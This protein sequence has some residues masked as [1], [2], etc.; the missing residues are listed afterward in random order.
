[1]DQRQTYTVLLFPVLLLLFLS[2]PW[3]RFIPSP[4]LRLL[5]VPFY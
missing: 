3:S 4:C 5:V 1:L 2:R